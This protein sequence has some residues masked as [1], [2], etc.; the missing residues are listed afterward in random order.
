MLELVVVLVHMVVYLVVQLAQQA[1]VAV[2][3]L[4]QALLERVFRL[5]LCLLAV[6]TSS[7]QAGVSLLHHG[8]SGKY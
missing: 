1:V 3:K 8:T 4:A 5:K 7:N 6:Y 2:H